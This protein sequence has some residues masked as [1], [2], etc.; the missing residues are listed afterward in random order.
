MDSYNIH[1]IYT[2]Y[3]SMVE[4]IHMEVQGDKPLGQCLVGIKKIPTSYTL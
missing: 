2:L 1:L 4:G 3:F